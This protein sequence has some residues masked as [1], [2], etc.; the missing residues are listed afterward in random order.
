MALESFYGGKQGISPVIKARFKYESAEDEAYLARWN[1]ETKLSKEEAIWLND[2]LNVNTYAAGNLVTWTEALLKPFTMNECFKDP[3]YKDVWYGE[4]CIIDTDN[5]LNPNNG[6]LYRRTL[7]QATLN[8]KYLYAEYIGQIVGPSGGIPNFDFGSLDAER[9]KAV[10]TVATYFTEQAPLDN[11]GWEYSYPKE[12]NDSITITTE[13]PENKD[14]I[15]ILSAAQPGGNEANIQMVPGKQND[16]YNDTIRYTWCNVRRKLDGKDDDAWVYLGFEIPYTIYDATGKEENYT[17]NGQIFIDN[18]DSNHPFCKN[19]TF[20]IPRGARGIGPE[21][22]F[23]VGKDGHNK[24]TTLYDFDAISYNQSTDTYSVNT[25][26]IKNP[27]DLTYW[28]AKWR[29]YNPKTTAITEVYQYVGAYKD[30]KA[31]QLLSTGELQI[32]Y[33]NSNNWNTLNTLTWITNANINTDDP[34]ANNYGQFNI[35]F[36]NNKIPSINENLHL[37]KNVTYDDSTGKITFNYSGDVSKTAGN[38]EY[39][40]SLNVNIDTTNAHYG[41]ITGTK[42]TG[43]VTSIGVLPLIKS[44]TYNEDSGIITFNYSGANGDISVETGPLNYISKMKI[45]DDGTLQYQNNTES[46][47]TWHTITN[48]GDEN[49]GSLPLKIKDIENITINNLGELI[50]TYR[51]NTTQNL[52]SVKG[53]A[54]VGPVYTLE[55][56]E[57]ADKTFSDENTALDYLGSRTFNENATTTI[58]GNNDGRIRSNGNNVTGGLVTALIKLENEEPYSAYYYYDNA[59]KVWKFA[60]S[61]GVSG[62]SG[63]SGNSNVYAWNSKTNEVYPREEDVNPKFTFSEDWTWDDSMYVNAFYLEDFSPWMYNASYLEPA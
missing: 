51:D 47:N 25:N 53:N 20:H 15:A 30:I 3:N 39:I 17:Y 57:N 56:L 8:N 32:Q 37:I 22:L 5:K 33:S 29:L 12:E 6:N 45:L 40:K 1:K 9:G 52:G 21:Q 41:E 11:S 7:R 58:G 44:S 34:N 31:V 62:T 50:V 55:N 61:L 43:T 10:G 48:T 4:L 38:I 14:S 13:I 18:S 46:G 60:G 42:N 36:N 2:A 27:T 26:K 24:P 23:V 16:T 35:T 63:Q 28:V 54:V 59:A 19:Y 49:A